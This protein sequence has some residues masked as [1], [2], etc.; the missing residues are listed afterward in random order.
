MS[1]YTVGISSPQVM[2]EQQKQVLALMSDVMQ[3][4]MVQTAQIFAVYQSFSSPLT[5]A[6]VQLVLEIHLVSSG[7][8]ASYVPINQSRLHT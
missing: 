1:H 2:L 6:V 4:I 7:F 8:I 5:T 3:T